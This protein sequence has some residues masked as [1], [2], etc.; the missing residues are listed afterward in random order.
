MKNATQMGMNRTGMAMSPRMGPQMI[1]GTE[2]FRAEA[3]KDGQSMEVVRA[4]YVANAIPVGTMPPPSSLKEAGVTAMQMLKGNKALVFMDKLGDRLAFERTGTRLYEALLPRL[5]A[6]PN[7]E[8]GPTESEVLAIHADELRH[9]A[10][11]KE[12]IERLGGDPTVQTPSADV[13]AVAS[14]GN[15][16]VLGDSRIS[17]RHALHAIVTIELVD[18]EGW[19]TLVELARSLGHDELAQQFRVAHLAEEEHLLRVRGWLRSAI[20]S[21]VNMDLEEQSGPEQDLLEGSGVQ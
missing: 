11:I 9:F 2:L 15:I 17:L 6:G 10:L 21:E 5:S 3:L 12:T 14:L 19:S 1:E 8:G 18:N 20:L 13:S 4:A 7:W 16:Q